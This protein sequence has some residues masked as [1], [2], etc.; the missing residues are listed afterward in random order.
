MFF[1]FFGGEVGG[2]FILFLSIFFF[3]TFVTKFMHG[4]EIIL[5]CEVV[6]L[7]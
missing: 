7:Y 5:A 6:Y 1:E 2:I 3:K 4:I